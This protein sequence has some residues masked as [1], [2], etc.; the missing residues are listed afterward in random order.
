MLKVLMLVLL[1]AVLG[2]ISKDL[3]AALKYSLKK[4]D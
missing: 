2:F 1:A 4:V 3:W